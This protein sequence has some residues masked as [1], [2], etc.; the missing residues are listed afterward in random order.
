[1]I[2][3]LRVSL[4][5]H[6]LYIH[7]Y[8]YMYIYIS[9]VYPQYLPIMYPYPLLYQSSMEPRDRLLVADQ[10][11]LTSLLGLEP[12]AMRWARRTRWDGFSTPCGK[13]MEKPWK[14]YGT[15]MEQPWN[16][17]GTTMEKLQ[18]NGIYHDTSPA[19]Q[20]LQGQQ[21]IGISP[22]ATV[23][24]KTGMGSQVKVVWMRKTR[25]LNSFKPWMEWWNGDLDFRPNWSR[26][27]LQI[28]W[29]CKGLKRLS[30]SKCQTPKFDQPQVSEKWIEFCSATHVRELGGT[31]E[32]TS[33]KRLEVFRSHAEMSGM[34]Q[35]FAW[36]FFHLHN[37]LYLLEQHGSDHY[38]WHENW[39]FDICWSRILRPS[40]YPERWW[41]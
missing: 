40:P 26:Q 32:Q 30:F 31:F 33:R 24:R 27:K 14:N 41:S 39:N 22:A 34:S 25:V 13:T 6:P 2:P 3:D 9:S 21:M 1:M 5:T 4:L 29:V 28:W 15:T 12:I 7:I 20:Q 17:H 38:K 36:T 10:R 37:F 16:N 11:A 23:S 19:I 8:M 35:H 18:F